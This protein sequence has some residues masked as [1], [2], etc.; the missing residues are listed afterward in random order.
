VLDVDPSGHATMIHDLIAPVRITNPDRVVTVRLPAFVHRFAAGHRVRLVVAGGST[1]YRG[2][3]VPSAVQ[4]AAGA[5]T[6]QLR[7][8]VVTGGQPSAGNSGNP[9]TTGSRG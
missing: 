1:N 8:P 2:N 7:L 9:G 4:I 5:A 3:L 6:Q